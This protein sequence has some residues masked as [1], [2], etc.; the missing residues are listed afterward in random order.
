M[1]APASLRTLVVFSPDY[2]ATNAY[3]SLLYRALRDAAGIEAV[4]GDV[5]L[6][7]R[8]A[9]ARPDLQVIFHLHWTAPITHGATSA[10]DAA[11]R[12]LA[13]VEA[14]ERFQGAGGLVAWT[15]HNVLPHDTAFPDSEVLLGSRLARL[16]DRI[17]V[18]SPAAIDAVDRLYVLPREKVTVLPPFGYFGV[19]PDEVAVDAARQRIGLT[20]SDR[21]LLFFGQL[22]AY[23]GLDRLVNAFSRV[24]RESPELRLVIAG[25]PIPPFRSGDVARWVGDLPEAVV[26][27]RRIEDEELPSFFAAADFVVL[28]YASVLTSAAIP[29]AAALARPVVAPAQG[30]IP[31]IVADGTTGILY[32]PQ[33]PDGLIGALRQV[34][35]L[36]RARIETMGRAARA[37]SAACDWR[38]MASAILDGLA[39]DRAGSGAAS[40]R[41]ALGW[42]ERVEWTGLKGT[43]IK[44][45]ALASPPVIELLHGKEI[46]SRVAAVPSRAEPADAPRQWRFWAPVPARFLDGQPREFTLRD[47]GG[48]SILDQADMPCPH[49]DDLGLLPPGSQPPRLPR[50]EDKA[51]SLPAK[52]AAPGPS[53]RVS[54]IMATCNRAPVIGDAIRSVQAQDFE[55]WELLVVDDGGSDDTAAAVAAFADRRIRLLRSPVRRGPAAARNQGLEDAKGKLIAYLDSDN[56]WADRYLRVMVEA[57]ETA[58]GD[59]PGYAAQEV[60]QYRQTDRGTAIDRLGIR[61]EPFDLERLEKRNY[62]DLSVFMHPRDMARRHGGFDPSLRRLND[63]QLIIR[64][65]RAKT[66]I[67][68]PEVLGTYTFGRV[69]DQVTFIE[70]HDRNH[71]RLIASLSAADGREI[72]A[73]AAAT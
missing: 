70:D 12:I 1:T 73:K 30:S 34:L 50:S 4:P 32:D 66:P 49:R 68:V 56:W 69:P 33:A 57:L 40:P 67:A 65:A 36:D 62:I 13:Y 11:R 44:E 6:A 51:R 5:A 37:R 9:S 55:D 71:A 63:W 58:G 54:I 7:Q 22:R 47:A 72:S 31:D 48:G 20:M 38:A 14:I 28:P 52:L 39:L 16:A 2:R 19:Y 61:F 26:V 46:V 60:L 17:Y 25:E 15:V 64:Y 35:A 8:I 3:Q 23:K 18:H 27:E 45:A 53:P 41:K 21:V 43:V 59:R 24:R 29:L 42:I 10:R